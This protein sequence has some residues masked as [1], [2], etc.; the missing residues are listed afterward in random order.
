M[1]RDLRDLEPL[2]GQ[3]DPGLGFIGPVLSLPSSGYCYVYIAANGSKVYEAVCL[4][5]FEDEADAEIQRASIIAILKSRFKE[6]LTF[7]SHY[8]MARAVHTRWP[9]DETAKVLASATPA[10]KPE[11]VAAAQDDSKDDNSPAHVIPSDYGQQLVDD[12]ARKLVVSGRA[13][14][15]ATLKHEHSGLVQDEI[16]SAILSAF[17][18]TDHPPSITSLTAPFRADNRPATPQQGYSGHSDEDIA[19]VS[20]VLRPSYQSQSAP[21][22]PAAMTTPLSDDFVDDVARKLVVSGRADRPATLKHEHFG[23]VQDEI[24]SAILSAFQR[25]DHPPSITSL[26]AP[27][28][29][30]NRPATPQQGYSGHSDEDIAAVSRALRPSYQSQSAPKLPAAMTTPLSDDRVVREQQ[31]NFEFDQNDVAAISRAIKPTNR[32]QSVLC[33]AVEDARNLASDLRDLEP[34]LGQ[35]DPGLGFIGPVL[36]LPSSGC[37]YVYIAANG[38]KVYEAVCLGFF[39]DEADA[40]I[41]RASII[42]IL[43][44]RFK[45]MLTFG[46]HYEMAR[47]VHTRWPNDET[48]KVLASATPATKPESVAAAQDDSKDDNSPAHVIPSDYGQQLVDDVARKLVVSGRADRP[49]TLKHE[50]SGLVQDE[51]ASAILSAFQRTDHPPS[52]TILTAPFR[53]D[54]R[55][56]TPQQGYSGHSDEDIAAVSRALR[57]SYQSQSAPK[58]PAAMTTPLSDDRVVR[59]QRGNFEF[60]QNNVAAISRAIKPTNRLQSVLWR[61][62][63][64]LASTAILI[65]AVGGA[66]ALLTWAMVLSSAPRMAHEVGPTTAPQPVAATVP[67]TVPTQQTASIKPAQIEAAPDEATA[68]LPS[69]QG[70]GTLGAQHAEANEP[71]QL[72]EPAPAAMAPP[73]P[74]PQR[75]GASNQVE[76]VPASS[77]EQHAEANE[78]TQLAEPPHSVASAQAGAASV[79]GPQPTPAQGSITALRLNSQEITTLMDGGSAY[80][81]RGDFASARLLFRRAAEAGSANAALML[82]ST[83]D[84]LIIR[85]FGVIGI[86]PDV[87]RASQ[88]YEKAEELGSDA[89]SQRLANLKNH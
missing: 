88:W 69:P 35:Y 3:Y 68:S 30:D 57:P 18:R 13:D 60:D 83:F 39:E 7:G 82:G 12:V 78:P 77:P 34:L 73:P 2:L 37:C 49:A 47:A 84:P 20:R 38:S 63:R 86:E 21:K 27:F 44:S 28:R 54:N 11:S 26:T 52:I 36:S 65:C 66:S 29:A 33:R 81:K 87:A 22:L 53:A 71:T 89:A 19:A 8:E 80:F 70:A 1:L 40:E 75:S 48:A 61:A 67:S 50:H 14:R 46:S 56:A 42:A 72:V 17:Q 6:M 79:S 5:F 4:G 43:K 85:Q 10:T 16:A 58:L 62:A 59:E 23:L 32:L 41:Q 64:N 55:P 9:N 24:A 51:I 76:A 31:G 74:T 45:E 25:T 15:P